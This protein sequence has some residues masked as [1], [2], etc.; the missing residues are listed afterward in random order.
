MKE[1]GGSFEQQ[2]QAGHGTLT[3]LTAPLKNDE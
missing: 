1:I 2:S 3:T